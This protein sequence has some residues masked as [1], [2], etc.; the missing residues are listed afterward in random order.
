MRADAERQEYRA[1]A[2]GVFH[3]EGLDAGFPRAGGAGAG[4][5]A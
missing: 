3:E 2:A 5:A 1:A 4:A